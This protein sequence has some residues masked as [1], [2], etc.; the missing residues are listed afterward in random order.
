MLDYYTDKWFSHVFSRG[1]AHF[2]FEASGKRT[3]LITG[4][5]HKIC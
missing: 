5:R 3:H 4:F 1:I 2:S